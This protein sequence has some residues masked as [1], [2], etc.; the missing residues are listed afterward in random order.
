MAGNKP[1][2]IEDW[3]ETAFQTAYFILE[4]RE[5]A[6]RVTGIAAEKLELAAATQGK[7]LYYRPK[8]DT[9]AKSSRSKAVFNEAHLLQ[10]LVLTETEPFERE[11]EASFHNVP[12]HQERLVVHYVKH[13]MKA[14][15]KRN[16]F[17]VTLAFCRL[18]YNYTTPET[19]MIFERLAPDEAE[20]KD[21]PYFRSRKGVLMGEVQ[22]RFGDLLKIVHGSHGE[23]KFKTLN[24]SSPFSGLVN[25][26]LALFA[27]WRIPGTDPDPVRPWEATRVAD[28]GESGFSEIERIRTIVHPVESDNFIT[29]IGLAP[30]IERLEIPEFQLPTMTNPNAQSRNSS[31]PTLSDGDLQALKRNLQSRAALRKATGPETLSICVDG[32]EYARFNPLKMAG[33]S[34]EVEDAAEVV[35]V[36]TENGDLPLATLFLK[37]DRSGETFIADHASITLE[38]GQKISFDCVPKTGGPEFYPQAT[39]HVGYRETAPVRKVGFSF[40]RAGQAIFA[41][42]EGE[43]R[44]RPAIALTGLATILIG[45]T[46][47][48]TWLL[49]YVYSETSQKD[50]VAKSDP[51]KTVPP[52][53]RN[54]GQ[55][56]NGQVS[57]DDTTKPE[58]KG[59]PKPGS[60]K[61]VPLTPSR[62][63]HHG[64]PHPGRK[65]KPEN[66]TRTGENGT[67]T[68]DGSSGR[69]V[70]KLGEVTSI[71]LKVTGSTVSL[72]QSF[73]DSFR[74]GFRGKIQTVPLVGE[75]EADALL[76][77]VLQNSQPAPDSAGEL[78]LS[79]RVS[80][81]VRLINIL[82]KVIWTGPNGGKF[83]GT[84]EEVSRQLANDLAT[85]IEKAQAKS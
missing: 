32:A 10:R 64:N 8:V 30:P 28:N 21:D 82:G 79:S 61:G 15:L 68:R 25:Q 74:T 22:Q 40:R 58:T 20:A 51:S 33:V 26:A 49:N 2:T 62:P 67:D 41:P 75:N 19:M 84:A 60:P 65:N 37:R 23:R 80:G 36:W 76:E 45:V 59:D 71:A 78:T 35:E 77:V 6:L 27:P 57:N 5:L 53:P 7:R 70:T 52:L 29:G 14:T 66:G 12:I 63:L 11:L 44:L 72:H 34:I 46:S 18:L 4:N 69:V 31:L 38:G 43:S 13:L 85:S 54:P 39:V 50:P 17:Y 83:S 47:G 56:L 3:L 24:E 9:G 16:S 73:L 81:S 1:N 48:A 55:G 42:A